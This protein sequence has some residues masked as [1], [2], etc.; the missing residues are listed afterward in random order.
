MQ[1]KAC[2]WADPAGDPANVHYIFRSWVKNHDTLRLA[3]QAVL[4]KHQKDGKGTNIGRWRD[5][6]TFTVEDNPDEL[7][8]ILGSPN[9]SG[10]AFFLI[11][12][13]GALGKKTINK[14]DVFVPNV[15]YTVR[16]TTITFTE[17]VAKIMFLF[18]VTDVD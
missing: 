13:K 2:Q 8:A 18:H 17:E 12:H 5:R 14:V 7:Y 15:P 6:I 1:T 10:S 4:N 3:F 16:G 9:G 11:T